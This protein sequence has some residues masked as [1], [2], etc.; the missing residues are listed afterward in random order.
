MPLDPE[1]RNLIEK[2]SPEDL[3]EEFPYRIGN[4][5][6]TGED[7]L[8]I[9]EEYSKRFGEEYLSKLNEADGE[10]ERLNKRLDK[11]E[12]EAPEIEALKEKYIKLKGMFRKLAKK[13]SV[14]KNTTTQSREK[15]SLIEKKINPLTGDFVRDLKKIINS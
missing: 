4:R 1:M 7:V 15:I 11:Y 8:E 6:F 9:I 2:L 10:I 5:I 12:E 13:Y 14:L 3:V